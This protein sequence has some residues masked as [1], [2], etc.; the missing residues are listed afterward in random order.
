MMIFKK[1]VSL[2][3][4]MCLYLVSYTVVYD[5][6][7]HTLLSLT[8]TFNRIVAYFLLSITGNVILVLIKILSVVL[9]RYYMELQNIAALICLL[10]GDI[11][12]IECA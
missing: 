7:F 4:C 8:S 9:Y 2:K 11:L 1:D 10:K 12:S 3:V 5:S 6:V